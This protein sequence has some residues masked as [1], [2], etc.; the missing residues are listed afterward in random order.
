MTEK[1]T[2]Q[3]GEMTSKHLPKSPYEEDEI[4]GEL[5]AIKTQINREANY[6]V[7]VL[8]LE[9]RADANSTSH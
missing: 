7:A 4:L 5:Y 3:R 8:L 1:I 6:D 2:S 9:A